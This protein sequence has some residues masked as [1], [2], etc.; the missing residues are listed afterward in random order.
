[1]FLILNLP[2]FLR[3]SEQDAGRP[4]SRNLDGV[5]PW[6]CR[7]SVGKLRARPSRSTTADWQGRRVKPGRR[8]APQE[9]RARRASL[10][11]ASWQQRG[12][13]RLTRALMRSRMAGSH[14][15]PRIDRAP[16]ARGP[17]SMRPW[18]QPTT[19]P[20]ASRSATSDANA[21]PRDTKSSARIPVARSSARISALV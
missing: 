21:S 18:N 17:N 3:L 10:P 6:N 14:G 8:P 16:S 1:M 7:C 4:P 15:S 13:R 12:A 5:R 11:R 9:T 2:V 19:L 20:L